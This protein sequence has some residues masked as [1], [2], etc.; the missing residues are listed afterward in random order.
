[1]PTKSGGIMARSYQ[2]H[3]AYLRTFL[4]ISYIS[5]ST[6]SGGCAF[7]LSLQ[8][9][10]GAP[11]FM[12]TAALFGIWA[13]VTATCNKV[14]VAE[15]LSAAKALRLGAPIRDETATRQS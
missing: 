14:S 7:Y 15:V 11:L 3:V 13:S 12:G 9:L 1:M 6:A 8:S 2:K 5:L 4:V 10:P